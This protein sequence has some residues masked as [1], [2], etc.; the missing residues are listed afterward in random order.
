MSAQHAVLYC[1]FGLQTNLGMVV[2][3]TF[4]SRLVSKKKGSEAEPL[5]LLT[6]AEDQRAEGVMS[7]VV[8][9]RCGTEYDQWEGQMRGRTGRRANGVQLNGLNQYRP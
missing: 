3:S 9:I 2:R 6:L 4:A 7:F 5:A 1:C 8:C